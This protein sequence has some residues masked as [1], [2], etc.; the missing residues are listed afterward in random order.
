MIYVR[1]C[2]IFAR[3]KRKRE[4]PLADFK[5][6]IVHRIDFSKDDGG[7]GYWPGVAPIPREELNGPLAAQRFMDERKVPSSDRKTGGNDW[8]DR[9]GAYT[10]GEVPYTFLGLANGRVDQ[11]LEVT[12][13]GPHAR[14]WS[15]GGVSY[16]CAGDFTVDKPEPKQWASAVE[17]ASIFVSWLHRPVHDCVFGHTELPES[18]ADPMKRCPGHEW[19]M[20]KFRWEIEANP[21]AQLSREDANSA[22]LLRGIT[23]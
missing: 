13:Y 1:D 17:I 9:P 12:E 19:D 3:D 4:T 15:W 21:L 8:R 6:F 11:M 2:T 14:R 18:S 7:G 20:D 23:L 10:G 16:A 5:R 22:L